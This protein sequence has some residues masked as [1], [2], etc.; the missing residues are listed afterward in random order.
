MAN[1]AGTAHRGITPPRIADV[2][3]DLA[4]GLTDRAI[5][6]RYGLK[7]SSLQ[8]HRTKCVGVAP[9]TMRAAQKAV[10]FQALAALPSRDEVGV[11]LA[12]IAA[13]LDAIIAPAEGEGSLAVG[14]G[15]LKELRSTLKRT[16][17]R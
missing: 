13:R 9:S 10:A 6:A 5:C 8:R 17:A 16:S 4:A 11:G 15:G 3:V 12:G 2:A 7:T 1:R 14:I